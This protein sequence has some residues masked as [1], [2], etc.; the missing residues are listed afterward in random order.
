[1]KHQKWGKKCFVTHGVWK[2]HFPLIYACLGSDV[3]YL[4]PH[5]HIHV[6]AVYSQSAFSF[7]FIS[8][9]ESKW[10]N[11]I[12][13]AIRKSRFSFERWECLCW[14]FVSFAAWKCV[15]LPIQRTNTFSS[16]Y[17]SSLLSFFMCMNNNLEDTIGIHSHGKTKKF[18][19][20]HTYKWLKRKLR[21]CAALRT[22]FSKFEYSSCC[23]DV[24]VYFWWTLHD[25]EHWALNIQHS[26]GFH[27]ISLI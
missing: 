22:E 8:T 21:N 7:D 10:A 23:C 2:I 4:L 6:V 25:D 3:S 17:A 15:S 5:C 24:T 9:I 20:K 26:I 11:G 12:A 1:M 19:E 16:S 18:E 27:F 14:W 13:S